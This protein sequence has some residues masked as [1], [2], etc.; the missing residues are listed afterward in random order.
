MFPSKTIDS[1]LYCHQLMRL[2][3]AIES[4]ELLNRMNVVFHHDNARPHLSIVTQQKLKESLAEMSRCILRI[5][6]TLLHQISS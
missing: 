4:A 1:D 2:K 5:A 3:K 6:L